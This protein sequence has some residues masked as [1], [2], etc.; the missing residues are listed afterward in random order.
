M[1][2]RVIADDEIFYQKELPLIF[3]LLH[4]ILVFSVILKFI[5]TQ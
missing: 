5:I 2:K 4:D 3:Y 1:S